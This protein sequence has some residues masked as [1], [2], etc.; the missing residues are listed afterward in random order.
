MILSHNIEEYDEKM[1]V[2]CNYYYFEV[3]AHN[4]EFTKHVFDE[5]HPSSVAN[6]NEPLV[7]VI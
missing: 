7:R 3:E 6:R 1:I 2:I 4:F 5:Q